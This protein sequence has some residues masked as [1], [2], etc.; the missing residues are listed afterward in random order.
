MSTINREYVTDNTNIF[1]FYIDCMISYLLLIA[2]QV[3]HTLWISLDCI[4]TN[5]IYSADFLVYSVFR[6]M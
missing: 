5:M 3:T 1:S 2:L 4:K 6:L